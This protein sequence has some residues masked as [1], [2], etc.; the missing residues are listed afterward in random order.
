MLAGIGRDNLSG[1]RA[2]PTTPPRCAAF[3]T[4]TAGGHVGAKLTGA[5]CKCG[6]C[7][8]HFNSVSTFDAH[9]V[10]SYA[11]RRC[12]TVAEMTTRGWLRN[13]GGFW[14]TSRM[15]P[16]SRDRARRGGERLDPATTQ[17]PPA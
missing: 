13:T 15:P 14:I 8:E 11:A 6:G 9:R 1:E 3:S 12:L 4:V 5:R 17:R 16:G 7:G 10:G 2:D